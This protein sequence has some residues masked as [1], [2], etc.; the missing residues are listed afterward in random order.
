MT[1]L[2]DFSSALAHWLGDEA[3]ASTLLTEFIWR[4]SEDCRLL[5]SDRGEV[6]AC[7]DLSGDWAKLENSVSAGVNLAEVVHEDD[8]S[9]WHDALLSPQHSV[10]LRL[11]SLVDAAPWVAVRAMLQPCERDGRLLGYFVTLKNLAEIKDAQQQLLYQATHD[12]LTRLPNRAHLLA[13]MSERLQQ[14]PEGGSCAVLFIDLDR[15]KI[16]NDSLGH[17]TGDAVL[18][19]ASERLLSCLDEHDILA[20]FGGD[21]FLIGLAV[22]ESLTQAQERAEV[23]AKKILR[24]MAAGFVVEADTLHVTASIGIGLYPE[25]SVTA[26]G[27]VQ[28]ADI[29]MYVVK[30]RGKNGFARHSAAM[31]NELFVQ[32]RLEQELRR[33]LAEE[34]LQVHYQ[35]QVSLADGRVFGVE[36]LA[37]WQHPRLGEVEPAVFLELAQTSGIAL[38]IDEY[39]QTRALSD[40][41]QWQ[42]QG[43]DVAVSVNISSAQ[44]KQE[45]FLDDFQQRLQRAEVA[46]SMVK[47]EIVETALLDGA[48]DI[49]HKLQVI[50]ALGVEIAIDDFGTGYSSLSY[51][52]QFPIDWLKIDKTFIAE[53]KQSTNTVLVD[54][55]L[56]MGNGLGMKL[57]AEGV[58]H[59]AQLAYLR[60]NGCDAVQGFLLSPALAREELSVLLK[61][62]DFSVL[63]AQETS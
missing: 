36:A 46:P 39:V 22:A 35:P 43:L 12:E 58:E 30:S 2:K 10:E 5:V 44:I 8:V 16:I 14:L 40:A 29:A 59:A 54:A 34:T 37:R 38:A 24:E 62:A 20:R 60:S 1:S 25:D 23:V 50:K 61:E 27:L 47:V 26:E 57:I 15:F 63:V 31:D 21:E 9:T 45:N 17:S 55:I 13:L 6:V 4:G 41:A 49:L 56:A 18:Q 51:L 48:D 19:Q 7:S 33:A 3:S 28:A 52:Q 42:H 32:T 11:R 53:L